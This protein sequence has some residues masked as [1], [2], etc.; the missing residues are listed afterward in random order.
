VSEHDLIFSRP[1][2]VEERLA[3]AHLSGRE[4]YKPQAVK[5]PSGLYRNA[6]RP[7]Q[8]TESTRTPSLEAPSRA[9]RI[10]MEN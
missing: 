8:G 10:M 6:Y 2:T 3:F 9:D 5:D 4:F 1:R 7:F